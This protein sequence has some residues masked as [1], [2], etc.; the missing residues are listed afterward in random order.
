[1]RIVSC[2]D[3]STTRTGRWTTSPA[4]ATRAATSSASCPIP[5]GRATRCWARPTA[6]CCCGRS[7]CPRE[8][9][10][11]GAAD[12]GLL[13]HGGVD[14]GLP[15]RGV[16]DALA[17]AVG[18][19]GGHEVLLDAREV[20]L[21]AHGLELRFEIATLLA[22]VQ[23]PEPVGL[24]ELVVDGSEPLLDGIRGALSSPLRLVRLECFEIGAH[25]TP[26]CSTLRQRGLVLCRHVARASLLRW[27]GRIVRVH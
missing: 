25:R 20:D 16:G 5:N 22:Q 14:A 4:S 7:S 9:R 6:S 18:L 12:P 27:H 19:G 2:C 26:L 11:A 15:P 24:F 3:M 10:S 1:M 17:L 23:C 13:Q 21:L 8:P